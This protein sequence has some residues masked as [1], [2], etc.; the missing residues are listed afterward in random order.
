MH[1]GLLLTD[2]ILGLR[3][4]P[5]GV[6]FS[7][8]NELVEN[9]NPEQLALLQG[10]SEGDAPKAALVPLSL[11]RLHAPIPEPC[12]DILCV[13]VNYKDHL[14][15][16]QE[17][18]APGLTTPEAPV[19]FSKRAV[20]VCG[21][22]D[23]VPLPACD[24]SLDY[25]VELAVVIGKG[26]RDIN[27]KN[28]FDHIFGFTILNDFSARKTQSRH[29]QWFKGKSLDG[30]T[31]MGPVLV[32]K[33]SFT[34]PLC[35]EVKSLVNNELRQQSNTGYFIYDIP[36]IIAEFSQGMTLKPGDIISTGTPGGVGMSFTPPR[37]LKP[38]DVVT[39]F[40]EG[41]GTLESII[42]AC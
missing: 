29:V 37:F 3:N 1:P 17:H 14:R 7:D 34:Y 27:P 9:I 41:I 12:H 8:L 28:A 38:G 2:G 33:S 10:W 16:T 5:A 25:E 31:A 26:G 35:L 23:F 15:E 36:E 4:G 42:S 30:L 24:S 18:F 40:I 13:G 11:A 21:P 32:H 19:L 39:C 6:S 22:G 20:H